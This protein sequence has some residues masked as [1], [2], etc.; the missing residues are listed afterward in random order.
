MA[1][2]YETLAFKFAPE[3]YYEKSQG[4]FENVKP[5]DMGGLYWR[6]VPSSVSWADVCIQYIIYF[7]EQC[8][9]PGIF[10]RFAGK[11]P[12]NHP[13]DYAPLFLYFKDEKPVRA[14]FDI[15]HYE[16]VG[17]INTPSGF[18][19]PDKR[20]Q[21]QIRYFYRG[22]VPLEKS[23]G[24]TP[25]GG[26]PAR[27]SQDRLTHWWNG[28][29][30]EGSFVEEAKLI[31]KEKLEDP[32][33]KIT[34]FRDRAGKLG[35]LFHWIFRSAKE[36]QVM[37]VPMEPDAVASQVEGEIGERARYFSHQDI[38]DITKFVNQNIFEK[39]EIPEYIALRRHK[40]IQRI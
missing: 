1:N 25:L 34:T 16:A 32:F 29:T 13:N 15:C 22:L 26:A 4:S 35:F 7:R 2:R 33:K 11:L 37:G 14:V 38:K 31:I 39:S 5:E 20:P 6:A 19:H 8:W 3:L 30:S 17:E 12:G 21:F 10:D 27:L 36:C 24:M 23:E 9:I 40:K 28:F 18:L